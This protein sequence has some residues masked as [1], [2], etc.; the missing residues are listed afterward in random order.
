[1]VTTRNRSEG[2]E[3]T[4]STT[5]QP[6]VT[7]AEVP[8][9][10]NNVLGG[11]T[12]HIPQ[13]NPETSEPIME[14]VTAE[15]RMMDRMM[16]AMNKAMA[17]QQEMF[18]KLLEDRD[19]NNHRHEMVAENVIVVG[20]G[21]TGNGIPMDGI[22]TLEAREAVK[23]C[24]FKTF[25]FC[26][27]PEFKGNDDPIVCMNWIHEM[28]H[29]FRTSECGEG[30]K[31]KFGSQML[32]GEALTLWNIYSMSLEASVLAKMDWEIF[33]RKVLEEYCNERA[34]DQII[35]EFRNLKKGNSIVKEYNQLFMYKLGLVGHLVLT[36]KKNIKAYIKGFS[37]DITNMVRVSKAST[38]WEEIEEAQLVEDFY[39]RGREERSG[40]VEKRKR[41]GSSVPSKKSRP[42]NSNQRENYFR[43]EAKWC[44]K[45]RSKH[46]GLCNLVPGVAIS[47]GKTGHNFKD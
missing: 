30:Q 46:F 38:L 8:L 12:E 3:V 29:D 14:E 6:Q 36:E 25:L 9:P 43:S 4:T 5:D 39:G 11:R 15:T 32:Q 13:R 18:L 1:M 41:E 22:A 33:K 31:A 7:A 23:T 47:S 2:H 24:T 40:V 44:S 26:R 21:G 16:M 17:Q 28:E 37:T 10:L 35:Y 19:T 34:M 42:F 27:P 45:C 20:S